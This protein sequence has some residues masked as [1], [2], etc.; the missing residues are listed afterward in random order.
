MKEN[1]GK[2]ALE[3]A[4]EVSY[5]FRQEQ[6]LD[7]TTLSFFKYA[8]SLQ[9]YQTITLPSF[10]GQQGSYVHVD[11][12]YSTTTEFGKIAIFFNDKKVHVYALSENISLDLIMSNV[13]TI[14]FSIDASLDTVFKN[15]SITI[16]GE[17]KK[18][19]VSR[20]LMIVDSFGCNIYQMMPNQKYYT[21][22][23]QSQGDMINFLEVTPTDTLSYF[24]D[25]CYK[26]DSTGEKV[27]RV[28][29][30]SSNTLSMLDGSSMVTSSVTG[31]TC[32]CISPLFDDEE[33]NY[34]VYY[35][36]DG[37]TY[38]SKVGENFSDGIQITVSTIYGIKSMTSLKKLS[39]GT[40]LPHFCFIDKK[41]DAYFVIC[42]SVGSYSNP[43][44]LGKAERVMAYQNN[45]QVTLF[46]LYQDTVVK[47][48]GSIYGS[49]S[50]NGTFAI[51]SKSK[52]NNTDSVCMNMSGGILYKFRNAV[53]AASNT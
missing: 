48:V 8:L 36:K 47:M 41:N 5:K 42:N 13:N 30:D 53:Y 19:I 7:N 29:T 37:K 14:K 45:S 22:T 35:V 49:S 3:L 50:T 12:K 18:T 16:S 46:L 43:Q 9:K 28:T 31:A 25:Y 10:I 11:V 51:T 27:G 44:K 38:Y 4:Q 52:I 2:E 24:D 26:Y 23:F 34:V 1:Y 15:I 21:Y 33:G 40:H 17:I 39:N 20:D 32:S 6:T